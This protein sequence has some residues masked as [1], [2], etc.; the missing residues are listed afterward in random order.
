MRPALGYHRQIYQDKAFYLAKDIEQKG[1][2]PRNN[3]CERDL[4]TARHVG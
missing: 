3:I 2:R 4:E 1:E